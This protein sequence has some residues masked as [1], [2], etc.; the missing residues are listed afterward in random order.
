MLLADETSQAVRL[1]P[2]LAHPDR[3]ILP[4]GKRGGWPS[5]PDRGRVA[6]TEVYG[7]GKTARMILV[8]YRYWYR[9]ISFGIKGCLWVA[10]SLF[11]GRG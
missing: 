5:C 2:D 8:S 11:S 10:F 6:D 7:G 4:S 9:N 3:S 1:D